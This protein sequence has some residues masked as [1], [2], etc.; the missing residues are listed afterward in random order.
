MIH[1]SK[2]FTSKA[3][4]YLSFF[5]FCPGTQ[6]ALSVLLEE[7]R[8]IVGMEFLCL[9]QI[10]VV[11]K[12]GF[13]RLQHKCRAESNFTMSGEVQKKSQVNRLLLPEVK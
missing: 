6:V 3:V 12:V 8:I 1:S 7:A 13:K 2:L 9:Y 4:M 10:I 11:L 5:M